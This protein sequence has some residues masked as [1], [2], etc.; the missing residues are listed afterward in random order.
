MAEFDT[1]QAVYCGLCHQLGKAYGPFAKLTLSYDFT[2]V[3]MLEMA[4]AT[5]FSGF[6]KTRC[7]GNPLKKKTCVVPCHALSFVS[8]CAMSMLYHK[9]KDNIHDDKGMKKLGYLALLPFASSARKK[10]VKTEPEIDEVFSLMMTQ[11]FA[12]EAAGTT[13]ID[14]AAEPTAIALQSALAMMGKDDPFKARILARFGYLLGRWVYLLDALDDLEEDA[15]KK[16]YNAFLLK[17]E[18]TELT[19]EKK[20]E[21]LDY[22]QGVL[23]ITVAELGAAYELLTLN[24]YKTILDNI[25]YQGMPTSAHAVLHPECKQCKK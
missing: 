10:V 1:Y 4:L 16:S 8:S 3:A 19:P 12:L 5:E 14:A 15:K 22:G 9:V 11:Q 18:V 7:M 13:S 25:I 17:F 23:N 21:I 6:Q 24:R 20:Q 2:F